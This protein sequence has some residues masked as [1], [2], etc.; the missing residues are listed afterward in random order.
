MPKSRSTLD[1]DVEALHAMAATGADDAPPAPDSTRPRTRRPSPERSASERT[2]SAPRR[3]VL[4]AL[5]VA[6]FLVVFLAALALAYQVDTFLATD[7]RF[8]LGTLQQDG[9]L[10]PGSPLELAGVEHTPIADILGVFE[11]DSG[12]S[13]YLLPLARR[14]EELR[15]IDWVRDASV[16]RIWPN[17]LRVVIVER[18]PVAIVAVSGAKPGDG[19][20]MKLVDAEGQLMRRPAL[21][22]F[23]L[24][25][26]FGLHPDQPIEYRAARIELLTRLQQEVEPLAARFS[27]LYVADPLN[28]RATLVMDGR[29]LT[30]ML[31]NEKYLSRVQNFLNNY[32]AVIKEDPLANLFDMRMEDKI[33]AKREGLSGV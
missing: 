1:R 11:R 15:A 12:R 3:R 4:V 5:I 28:V 6:F 18:T 31:G 30:L 16:S 25:V 14:R 27:E 2:A 13:L 29:N 32:E 20:T 21:A 17:R 26:V 10:N 19:L 24:P 8:L 9:E 7:A 33:I 22:S 23:N